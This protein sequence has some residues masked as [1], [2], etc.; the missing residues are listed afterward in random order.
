MIATTLPDDQA[1][2]AAL[3][4]KDSSFEGIFFAAVKTTGIFCRP[5]CTARK[6]KP[7]NVEYFASAREAI[8]HGYRP[9]K[10]CQPL[11]VQGATPDWLRVLLD[12]VGQNPQRRFKDVDLAGRGLEPSRVRRWFKKNHGITFQSYLRMLRINNAF[13]QI[14]YGEK[15][16][17]AAY[18]HGF[19]S[20]SGFGEA[21][22]RTTGFAPGESSGKQ[23]I[24]VTRVL[25]PLGPMLAGAVED[26]L[27]LLEFTDRRMLETQISRLKRQL[28]AELA[29][30]DCTLFR[31]LHEQLQAY[32]A[33]SL[34]AFEIPLSLSGTPFQQ[35]VWAELQRIPF[36]ATRSYKQQAEAIGNPAAVRAV[37]RANGDNRIGI[38]VPCHRV[39]GAQGELV[40][41]G[42]G[43]WR[44]RWLL[45]HEQGG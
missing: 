38:I 5:T 41:Y 8:A 13:G 34:K 9:C 2:Y 37:A 14:K 10:V 24:T 44:K 42:G 21:F 32:F 29:P 1:M 18:D 22:K 11:C 31:E 12:E 26:R 35:R 20:L 33:G 45:A 43:L 23:V 25:T 7:E 30:G 3:L 17:D 28:R 39:I 40:G 4:H 15:I 16:V 19:E 27:C 6:P 36:G